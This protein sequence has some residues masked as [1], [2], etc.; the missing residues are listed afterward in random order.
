MCNYHVTIVCYWNEHHNEEYDSTII[1]DNELDADL[2]A[3]ECV[4][5]VLS[6]KMADR[7]YYMIKLSM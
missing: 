2:Y 7:C 3:S 4:V 5:D 1:F 6:N